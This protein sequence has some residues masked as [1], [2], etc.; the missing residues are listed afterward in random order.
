M[1]PESGF[2]ESKAQVNYRVGTVIER[3]IEG[4]WFIGKIIEIDDYSMEFTV[5]YLER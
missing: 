3:F 2:M 5:R 1:V 4:T